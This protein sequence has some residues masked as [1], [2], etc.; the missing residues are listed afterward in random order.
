ME[1]ETHLSEHQ[2]RQDLKG[3]RTSEE[4]AAK[5]VLLLVA[6]S[7]NAFEFF[8]PRIPLFP[9]LKPG[10]ANCVTI[11][12]IIRYGTVDALLFTLLRIWTIGF[13]FGFSF[14]TLVLGLCGGI[15]ATLTMG[16]L[17]ATLGRRGWLGIIGLG[18]CGATM[19][20]AGQLIAVSALLA[21][22]LHVFYQIPIMLAAS[23][24][25]GALVSLLVPFLNSLLCQPVS[26]GDAP[27]ET[28]LESA[29]AAPDI[30]SS[31]L[32][33][34]FCIALLFIS[35]LYVLFGA[36]VFAASMVQ[37][38]ERG[39]FRALV[40]P[41][42]TFW[43]LF[44]AVGALHLFFSYG[45]RIEY[46]PFLTYEG[47]NAAAVQ[48][49]RLWSWLQVAGVLGRF[50]F[51]TVFFFVLRFLFG[52]RR[53]TIQSGL[54]ALEHF[55]AAIDAV[56]SKATREWSMLFRHPVRWARRAVEGAVGDV[57]DQLG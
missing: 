30:A 46:A 56:R 24:L 29:P 39:S 48:W 36:A 34:A 40:R 1:R 11:L 9:W 8:I 19:H 23:V 16:L 49:L 26:P 47:V 18:I 25:F 54:V 27:S 15:L 13:Y 45:K 5:A 50:K 35:N 2:S 43:L 31:L 28:A 21:R 7:L 6:V 41:I 22:N 52:S 32:V 12:W 14:L 42:R 17:W 4:V 33:F 55:P 44:A 37:G 53:T 20:N 3:P 51:H 57:T 10:L 38:L